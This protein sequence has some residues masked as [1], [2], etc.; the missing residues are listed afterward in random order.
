MRSHLFSRG[1]FAFA[2]I[3]LLAGPALAADKDADG[4]DDA[5][6]NCADVANKSQQDG[7]ADDFGNG[8]DAD[9]DNDDVVNVRDLAVLKQRFFTKDG[10][11]DLNGDGVVN[12]RD[13]ALL[14]QRFFRAPGPGAPVAPVEGTFF[15]HPI[16]EAGAAAANPI[17]S[18]IALERD[19][20]AIT[21]FC[22]RAPIQMN[23]KSEYVEV[24]ARWESCE[25]FGKDVRLT[26]RIDKFAKLTLTAV[27]AS[28]LFPKFP[29]LFATK[30]Y[31]HSVRMLTYNV[32]MLPSFFSASTD[33]DN[34]TRI[35]RRIQASGY[36]F[37]ALN[38]VFD[39]DARDAFLDV[40]KTPYPYHVDYLSG[41]TFPHED[42]GLMFFSRFPFE[43][44]PLDTYKVYKPGPNPN[45]PPALLNFGTGDCEATN[46]D[47]VAYLEFQDCE[48]D[49]CMAEK[50]VGFVR[51]RNP[52]NG[53]VYNVA[54]T[55]MQAS[56]A[57]FDYPASLDDI[58]DAKDEYKVRQKQLDDIQT[59]ISGSLTSAEFFE[60]PIL[61]MGDMNVDGDLADPIL[62]FDDVNRENLLEWDDDFGPNGGFFQTT[63]REG[64]AYENAP[65]IPSGNYDR[66]L[67]N[68]S[69][70]GAGS[71]GARLDYIF[72]ST[73][74][75]LCSQHM[76]LAHNLRWSEPGGTFI[77]TGLGPN[78]VGE[79]GT[80]DLSDHYGVDLDMNIVEPACSPATADALAPYLGQWDSLGGALTRPGQIHWYR[81]DE[82]GTY[83]F[84]MSSSSDAEYRVYQ[85]ADLTTPAPPFK[86]E[87]T[88][89]IVR[90]PRTG[91]LIHFIGT[92][93]RAA[94]PP[95]Y[96]RVYFADRTQTGPYSLIYLLHDCA[97]PETACAL[98][99]S[100][101]R[102][103][104][105]GDV[106]PLNGMDE[107]WFELVTE[108][109]PSGT[110]QAL[111]FFASSIDASATN[112]FS[113]E[114]HED[115]GSGPV[116]VSTTSSLVDDPHSPG[117]K[118]LELG[119]SDAAR[120]KYYLR[121]RRT[122]TVPAP[123]PAAQRQ[124]QM[125]WETSLTIL[126][127][128]AQGGDSLSLR[129]LEE[130][131][132]AIDDGDDEIFI[133]SIR[134][135][136]TQVVGQTDLGD[137]DAGN[138]H[139]LE[140][141][142]PAPLHFVGTIEFE[143]FE[144]DGFA[145]GDADPMSASI[146]TLSVDEPG[147]VKSHADLYPDGGRYRFYYNLTHGFDQ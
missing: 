74:R 123:Y 21:G 82:A 13:L 54:F 112:V 38:E 30:S 35:A 6:D 60:Q 142:I 77:E 72:K 34:A 132:P 104:E 68:I 37:L 96:V 51:V 53:V 143:G 22:P 46:C 140:H 12:V 91:K 129:C 116:L 73:Q 139:D 18:T 58:D 93:Y 64:W 25:A 141:V 27:I 65:A 86:Q 108:A 1:S 47:R 39:E 88:D 76:T 45:P 119:G 99:P 52:E 94:T 134:V 14:K 90:D 115:S 107:A 126:F 11:A 9:F 95:F 117:E 50:G 48:D 80:Q 100:Q 56:Y 24:L 124:F 78:G 102:D 4:V 43:P 120:T 44:L 17:L 33:P 63:L 118:R 67:T 106:A 84:A 101:R 61:V 81:F 57:P 128:A 41:G 98:G 103:F 97:T 36:D 70:W 55:H 7:D 79:G 32:Q 83:S 5:V 133:E 111:S 2:L 62:S 114:L 89:A 110:P 40:L 137:F 105:M 23:V 20:V 131:D 146:G 26:M 49:D 85:A 19:S 59:I 29:G 69:A 15:V 127:G 144:D 28:S 109:I 66:G 147:P 3:L 138:P 125:R 8:C 71:D 31:G 92:E 136:G 10:E 16:E 42:S 135:D 130:N 145:N 113:F 121:V 122:P 87:T 75:R